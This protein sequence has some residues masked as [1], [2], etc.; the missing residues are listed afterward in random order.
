MPR[1]I[2]LLADGTGNSA[3]KAFKTNVWR[4]Y[5][6]LDLG[7]AGQIAVFSDGVGTSRFR[8]FE[9]FGLA[10]GFGV[11]RRVLALYKFLCLNFREGDNIYALGFSRGAFTIRVVVGLIAREGLVN[12]S[13]EEELNRNALAAYRAYRKQAF[14]GRW[15]PWVWLS[16]ILRNGLVAAKNWLTRSRTYSDVRPSEGPR[17]SGEIKIRFVGVWDTV[18][19]YGLPVDELTK[20]VDRWIWPMTFAT[21]DLLAAV[22]YGRQAF[23]IDDERRT[24]FPMRW[25]EKGN[26]AA[27]P[28]KPPRL[29]QV[30]FAGVHANV[31][32]GYPDDR[33]AYLPLC[34]MI[35]EAAEA[36]LTFKPDTVADY[37]D[38]ASESGRIYDSRSS[39]GIFY[40]YHPRSAAEL[41]G[42]GI[43]PIIDGSVIL[44]IVHG[45]DAYAPISLPD[46]VAVLTP[47]G[48][49]LPFDQAG[50]AA[51]AAG[52][53][54]LEDKLPLPGDRA[55]DLVAMENRLVEAIN[56]LKNNRGRQD[57]RA[58]RVELIHDTVWW[59]RGVYYAMLVF[60]VLIALYPLFA[61]GRSFGL[62]E[63]LLRSLSGAVERVANA[64][65]GVLPGLA[66]PWLDAIGAYPIGGLALILAFAVCY[67]FNS[68]LRI[69]INDRARAAW[70]VSAPKPGKDR[71]PLLRIARAVRYSPISA[72]LYWLTKEYVLPAVFLV[73]SI[74]LLIAVV[75][76]ASF[77]AFS[78]AGT[79]CPAE[80][81]DA[82]FE[83]TNPCWNSGEQLLAGVRYRI[84]MTIGK[85][86]SDG[87]SWFDGKPYCADTRGFTA[88]AHGFAAGL[89]FYPATPFKR[90]WGQPWFKPIAR[91]GRFGNEEYALDPLPPDILSKEDCGNGELVAEIEPK[92]SEELYLYVNDA[93]IGLRWGFDRFYR[94]NL[95]TAEVTVRRLVRCDDRD[96]WILNDSDPAAACTTANQEPDAPTPSGA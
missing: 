64:S 11:K 7:G 85:P 46:K 57:S 48:R 84:T 61:G 23:S 32:G 3:A 1:N 47:L 74:W 65:K 22:D 25:N 39:L 8:P 52:I 63:G 58:D 6:A 4:F 94:N 15:L 92:K 40:R 66:A 37:W 13:S 12:F 55:R 68:W 18:A 20:A 54:A 78:S 19:A 67:R 93:A 42:E 89:V 87:V 16:R 14:P 72:G 2:V 91:V 38:L 50:G 49:R 73:I 82:T 60:G 5:E 45:S 62:P 81:S 90:W 21:A 83:T 41:M 95:G 80:R 56:H 51:T 33:L 27:E 75:N 9:I 36:G 96:V 44:H 76:K 30:W 10:L 24:F 71:R 26:A 29:L 88:G 53:S 28:G 34:W 59:R 69:R 35:G 79:V 31:G 86:W 17:S 70:N 43:T 77:E